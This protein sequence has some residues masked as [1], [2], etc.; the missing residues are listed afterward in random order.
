LA[1]K[2]V[3]DTYASEN[4]ALDL[5]IPIAP[6]ASAA[7]SSATT[8]AP[9]TTMAAASTT[10]TAAVT[11]PTAAPATFALRTRFIHH[12]RA[13]HKILAVQCG[14]DFLRF[15]IV[16]NFSETESARLA[17]KTVPQQAER[18]RLNTYFGKQS[19]NLL[20]CGLEREISYVQFL[21]DGAP[22]VPAERRGH[23][24]G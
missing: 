2:I 7:S 15:R 23:M 17:R 14:N 4:R 21:H 3:F 11:S 16:F 8:A 20:F 1:R 10:T 22:C 6:V 5:A 24:R 18:I 19:L 13:A 12:Q 9:A